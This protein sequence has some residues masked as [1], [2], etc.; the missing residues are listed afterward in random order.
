MLASRWS[1]RGMSL[2][3]ALIATA[4]LAIGLIVALTV[5]DASRKAFA[6]GENATEQQES[7]RIAYDMLTSDIRMLGFNVNPDGDPAR[8]DEQLEGALE[9]AIIFRG[10]FDQSDPGANQTPEAS[11]AGGPFHNVSTGNDEIVAYVLSKPDGTGPD[12][13]IFQADVKEPVRDGRVE[14]VSISN[15]VLNPTSPPYT[16]YRVTFNNDSSTYGGSGFVV[17]TP[18]VENVQNMSFVYK[19]TGGEFRD[20]S[21]TIP[22]T[23]EA[24]EAR[25]GLTLVHVSL[26]GM[27]RQQDLNYTD[28]GDTATPHFRKFEL[29]GDVTPRNMRF[30]GIQDLS[31]DVTPPGKPSTPTLVP[32]HCDGLL[33]MW[34]ANP[35]SDEVTQYRV[36]WGIT[37]G[38]VTASRNVSGSPLYLDLLSDDTT[39]FVTVQAQ[40][41]QGNISVQSDPAS[42]R[43]TNANTPKPP[44][45]VT[46]T[47]DLT[48]RVSIGWTP[49]TA[50]TASDPSGDPLAPRIRDLAGYRI[51]RDADPTVPF[52]PSWSIVTPS[53]L[54][55]GFEQPYED[56]RVPACVDRY[57]RLTAV[58]T[59]GRESAPT[60]VSRG[61]IAN[62]G[63]KPKPP[64]NVSTQI[65][66][67]GG[68]IRWASITQDVNG[69]TIR[70]DHYR[71]FRSHPISGS[72]PPS[73]AVWDPTP[74]ADVDDKTDYLDTSMPVRTGDEVLYYRVTGA[75][76]C[77]NESDPSIAVRLDCAFS[78]DVQFA[79]PTDGQ[80]VSGSVPITVTVANGTDS[81]VAADVSYVYGSAGPTSLSTSGS[82]TRWTVI[83]NWY[84][85]PLGTYTFTATVTNAAG[86]TK[87]ASIGINA[88]P[89]S[90]PN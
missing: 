61:R 23:P 79:T 90:A 53:P 84:A 81:Y 60:P 38:A 21:A 6:K 43:T 45:D 1:E 55:P 20:G 11:L 68:R 72:L 3:E 29:Q 51:Y 49:V 12:T 35:A 4:V 74:I 5:Y 42:T 82:G 25:S 65:E 36:N 88:G 73:F 69:Q 24:K 70:I 66:A 85:S 2:I 37:A 27:T 50:N 13:I 41:A 32:G 75:D 15:V 19:G 14:P 46:T 7:I 76:E 26:V 10:D 54:S 30:K 62:S 16:L 31:A 63:V 33:V 83:P 67:S 17:R 71:V 8:P 89:A 44:T 52:G 64:A 34:D 47:T 59:C 87:S 86:C 39:Y 48:Y 56:R 58:D 9:H 77:V 57:Y 40:D 28:P 18:V 22:E 80:T 78:G